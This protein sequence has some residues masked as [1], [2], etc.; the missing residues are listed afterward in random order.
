MN[1]LVAWVG[2]LINRSIEVRTSERSC[3]GVAC[4]QTC[5]Y[6]SRASYPCKHMRVEWHAVQLRSY[7]HAI[8]DPLHETTAINPNLAL[9]PSIAYHACAQ[10]PGQV[11]RSTT[12]TIDR[13]CAVRDACSTPRIGPLDRVGRGA[14]PR[15]HAALQCT[16]AYSLFVE[17]ASAI[18]LMHFVHS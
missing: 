3:I 2:L 6:S 15:S 14:W 13:S 17:A 11:N 18:E 5:A 7:D 1:I 8:L 12:S 9:F 10:D 4:M 16:R